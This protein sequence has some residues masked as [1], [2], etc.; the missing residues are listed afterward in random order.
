MWAEVVLITVPKPHRIYL[1][2][3]WLALI[4]AGLL[5]LRLFAH[6]KVR[7][8]KVPGVTIGHG[9]LDVDALLYL[10]DSGAAFVPPKG[11]WQ[12]ERPNRK[13]PEPPAR[14]VEKIP[15]TPCFGCGDMDLRMTDTG[16]CVACLAAIAQAEQP[17]P[18]EEVVEHVSATG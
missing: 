3:I 11:G 9:P 15:P 14:V 10:Q 12:L 8:T 5:G 13:T 1:V 18:V 2:W 17:E 6:R 16:Y 4:P 7:V